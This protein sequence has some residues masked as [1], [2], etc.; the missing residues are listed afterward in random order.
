MG[1]IF[2]LREIL[3]LEVC[4]YI[5]LWYWISWIVNVDIVIIIN[6]IL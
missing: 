6:K 4:L 2:G 5:L 1:N 3:D